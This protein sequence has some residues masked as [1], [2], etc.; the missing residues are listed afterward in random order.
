LISP[1]YQINEMARIIAEKLGGITRTLY[2][3]AFVESKAARDA[4]LRSQDILAITELW[5]SVTIALVGIGKSPFSYRSQAEGEL[6]FGQFYLGVEEQEELC[7]LGVAGDINARFFGK[8][9]R[10]LPASIHKRIIGMHLEDL[11]RV[12]RDRNAVGEQIGLFRAPLPVE[13]DVLITDSLTARELV[14]K[15]EPAF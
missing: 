3:P 8:D 2:A 6:Q 11:H 4:I 15:V 1:A 13:L 9:G 5:R 12:P 7:N 14:K 10:E